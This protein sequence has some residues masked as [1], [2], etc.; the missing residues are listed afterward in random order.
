MNLETFQIRRFDQLNIKILVITFNIWVLITDFEVNIQNP[1][2]RD[3]TYIMSILEAVI[4]RLI[5]E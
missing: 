3:N 5:I 2:I 4:V 1:I